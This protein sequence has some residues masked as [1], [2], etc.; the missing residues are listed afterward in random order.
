M[1]RDKKILYIVSSLFLGGLLLVLFVPNITVTK[2]LLS[3]MAAGFA[4]ATLLLIKKRSIL[5]IN[6]MQ[7]AFLMFVI[8]LVYIMLYYLTGI[9]FGFYKVT[10]RISSL[11]SYILPYV[12]II[13]SSEMVRSVLLA[14]KNKLVTV[15]SYL[16]LVIL[17]I[18]MYSGLNVFGTFS[19]F[20]DFVG[21]VLFPAFTNNLLYHY[22]SRKYG[23]LPNS[24][25]RIV[26]TV[27]PYMIP[28]EPKTPDSLVAFVK[29]IMPLI[30]YLFV[31]SLYERRKFVASRKNRTVRIITG[32]I[33]LVLMALTIMLISC[34]FRFGII[35]VG[36]ESMTGTANKGDAVVFER[37]DDQIIEEGEIAIFKKDGTTV[38]HRIV[39]IQRINGQN[40]YFTKGDANDNLDSGYITDDQIIGLTNFKIRFIG[41]PT[42][43][44]RE[45]FN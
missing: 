39:D 26:M 43:W 6:K 41:Y 7:V 42:I 36:S 37:Y 12:I 29:L 4:V 5:S 28:F 15:L 38:I 40:R 13:V 31:H 8:A 16:A 18:M 3:L 20:M 45:L 21:M 44:L 11:W 35:V 22:L 25:Y 1:K 14:Q 19:R 34:Q 24:I 9:H 30:I 17:D 10:L 2:I 27:Y 23:V 32:I 33:L